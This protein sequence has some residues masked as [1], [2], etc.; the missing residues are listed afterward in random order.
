MIKIHP[1]AIIDH[2]AEIEDGV[3]IGP[4]T[5][6][7]PGVKIGAETKIGPHVVIERDTLIGR[8]NRIFA[9]VVI[10]TEAQHLAYKGEPSRVEIGDENIIREFV[11]I[12][13]GT[14]IDEFITRVGSRCMV[15]AY[16]HIAHDCQ[17]GDGVIIASG[18]SLAGHVRIGKGVFLGGLTGVHQFCRIGEYAFVGAFSGVGKDVPPYVKV[19]GIPAGIYDLNLIGLR[20]AGFGSEVIKALRKAL[21]IYLAS[22]GILSEIIKEI[23]DQVDLFPE[24]QKFVEFIRKPSRQGLIKKRVSKEESL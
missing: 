21:K 22:S 12:H 9:F 15:M 7:G 6:I 17:I 1:T 4:Y 19:F 2:R 16:V 13:R 14:A 5:I 10:G 23:E 20:R 3:E 18:A 11:T 8:R 24:V